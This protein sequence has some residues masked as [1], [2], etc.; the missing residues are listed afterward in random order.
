MTMKENQN[1]EFKKSLA[2]TEE[3]L[4]TISLKECTNS[5]ST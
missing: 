4:E 1:L 2:E 3:I 5:Q